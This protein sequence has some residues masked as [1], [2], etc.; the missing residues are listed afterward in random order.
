M[1]ILPKFALPLAAGLVAAVSADAAALDSV[2]I[3]SSDKFGSYLTDGSGRPL[4][5]FTK[6][7]QGKGD[8]KATVKCYDAC[9]AA[10]PP[11]TGTQMPQASGDVSKDKLGTV[12]R[13]D[14]TQQV[15]YNGWP[16]YYFIKDEGAAAPA[17]Q[18]LHAQ[19]GEWYLLKPD[20]TKVGH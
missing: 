1:S 11:A 18:D 17:G 15:T 5:L 12:E 8:A 14:G 6:D 9:A 10:W 4:Y 13:K 2:Q 3:K 7:E 20:G 16:L 19:G